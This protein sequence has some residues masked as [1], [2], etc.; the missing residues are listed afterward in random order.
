MLSKLVVLFRV[1]AVAEALSWAALLAG[2]VAKYLLG[3]GDGGV[4][5]FGM[6]HGML[7]L[8]YVAVTLIVYRV[9][10]WDAGTL[11]LAGVSGVLPL[12]SWPFELWAL[13][14]GKLDAPALSRQGGVGLYVAVA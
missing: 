10:R 7:F 13:R 2:M 5:V 3:Q 14:T 6:I 12:C 9:L 11:V 8:A 1:V 4:P